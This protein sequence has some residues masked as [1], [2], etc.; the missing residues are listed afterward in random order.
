M[1]PASASVGPVIY[2]VT[3]DHSPH[4]GT[5]RPKVLAI[6]HTHL[7]MLVLLRRLCFI[8]ALTSR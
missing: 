3:D 7:S 6:C 4:E 8:C 5:E 1:I 2:T